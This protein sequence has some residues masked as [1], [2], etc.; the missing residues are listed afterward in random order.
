MRKYLEETLLDPLTPDKRKQK[1]Y[2]D[3][4]Q[5]IG[6]SCIQIDGLGTDQC[7]QVAE[8]IRGCR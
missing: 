4:A 8:M 1:G 6:N 5:T 2:L 7:E 3:P